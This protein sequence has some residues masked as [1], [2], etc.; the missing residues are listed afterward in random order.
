MAGGPV[1]PSSGAEESLQLVVASEE[2]VQ[3]AQLALLGAQKV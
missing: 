3:S 1:E 2:W